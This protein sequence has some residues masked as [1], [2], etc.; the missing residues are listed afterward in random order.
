MKLTYDGFSEKGMRDGMNQDVMGMFCGDGQGLFLVSDGMG[1]HS[2]GERAS[3]EVWECC[4]Q[5]WEENCR[6][7]EKRE[8]FQVVEELKDVLAL[9]SRKIWDE[10]GQREVCGA[11]VVLLWIQQQKYALIWSGDSRCY[12][13]EHGFWKT[14][15]RQMTI[16]DVW[17]NQREL[18]AGLSKE[19]IQSHRSWGKLVRAAGVNKNFVCTIQTGTLKQTTLFA[20]CS[21]GVYKYA[22][23]GHLEEIVKRAAKTGDLKKAL[24]EIRNRVYQ[25]QAPDNLSC[26]LV[27]FTK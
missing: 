6:K 5:W 7:Q 8:I 21:D 9:A 22:G 20:L 10:T 18:V 16:D 13:A 4:R 26:V 23:P 14:G 17:E 24:K 15:I 19:E 1:G 27:R 12:K 25:N 3:K 2:E 11:T